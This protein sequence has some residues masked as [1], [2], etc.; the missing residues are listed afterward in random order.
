MGT[1]MKVLVV[2]LSVVLSTYA[3]IITIDADKFRAVC[4]AH[5]GPLPDTNDLCER[6]LTAHTNAE[7]NKNKADFNPH[8][9][10]LGFVV[11]AHGAGPYNPLFFTAFDGQAGYEKNPYML[12]LSQNADVTDVWT[13][14]NILPGAMMNDK[15]FRKIFPM[16]LIVTFWQ[17]YSRWMALNTQKGV[18][19][20]WLTGG[21]EKGYFP[22]Q[23][24]RYPSFWESYEL[25]NM[26]SDRVIIFHAPQKIVEGNRCNDDHESY[27]R[28]H[29]TN[30][31]VQYTCCELP[32]L[33]G[34]ITE[35]GRTIYFDMAQTVQKIS[36]SFISVN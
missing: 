36:E 28:L 33:S 20:L 26:Q 30:R 35:Y 10:A 14:Y 7:K 22:P 31:K 25:P 13:S 5:A 1:A 8:L 4:Q 32:P 34:D 16:F 6:G 27:N 2:L 9:N 24:G 19:S 18:P 23:H 3:A 17:Q 21:T 15:Q 11:R 29:N 12:L